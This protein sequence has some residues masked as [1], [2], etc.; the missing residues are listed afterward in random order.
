[1]PRPR[2]VL[3]NATF[4]D[5]SASGGPETYLR[6]LGEALAREFPLVALTVATTGSGARALRRDGW[7]AWAHV[8]ALPC[9]DGQRLRRQFAEQALVPALARRRGVDVVHSLASTAPIRAL[10]P[11]VIT[12]HD[13]TFLVRSTFG[14]ATTWGMREVITRAARHADALITGSVAARDEICSVLHMDPDDFLVVPHGRGRGARPA[15]GDEARD[16]DALRARRRAGRA[17]RRRQASRT[18]TR[19]S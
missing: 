4:L 2:H 14:A 15:A 8:V 6:G 7:G 5:P 18:R 9:E 16:A 17:V 3:L 11:A 1:M 10:S 12:L 19:R 13:V